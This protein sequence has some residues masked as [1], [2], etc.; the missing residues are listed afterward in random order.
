MRAAGLELVDAV[1]A[2]GEGVGVQNLAMRVGIVTGEVAVT[3]G[4]VQQG[5][6]AGA[7]PATVDLGTGEIGVRGG[8]ADAA[9]PPTTPLRI[10][11]LQ[12]VPAILDPAPLEVPFD[13]SAASGASTGEQ[14]S[15]TGR[16]ES[17][18]QQG[19][20]KSQKNRN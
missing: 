4:A 10:R 5:M 1:S 12:K 2:L 17:R 7:V 3:L 19:T 13:E 8:G 20:H 15:G 6:V 9:V 18:Q 14:A 11:P 16:N